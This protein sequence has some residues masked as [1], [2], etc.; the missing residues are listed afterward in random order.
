[1]KTIDISAQLLN[2]TAIAP[3]VMVAILTLVLLI[4]GIFA[5][6]LSAKFYISFCLISISLSFALLLG[7]KI[8]QSGFFGMIYVDKIS[9]LAQIIVLMAS[10]LFVALHFEKQEFFECKFK[11]YFVLFLFSLIGF[12]LMLSSKNLILIF[13][14]LE[15]SSLCIYTMIALNNR[16]NS[17]AAAIKYFTMGSFSSAFF[18]LGIALIY[19]F[20]GSFEIDEILSLVNLADISPLFLGGVMILFCALGFKLS[21]IPFHS[22]IGDVYEA[23][24]PALAGYIATIPKMA[25]LI[26]LMRF[27]EPLCEMNIK[28][29]QN[30]LYFIAVLT[31]SF[32]NLMAYA[33]KDV[34]KM[35]AFS[36]ISHSGFALSAILL[37][38]LM[39]NLAL[40]LYWIM[41]LV[42]NLGAFAMLSFLRNDSQSYYLEDF[43]ALGT[44]SPKFAAIFGLFMLSLAGIP[45]F[46]LFFGKMVLFSATIS[47]N[48]IILAVIMALNSAL[49]VYYYLRPIVCM[50]FK[51]TNS[52]KIPSNLTIQSTLVLVFALFASGFGLFYINWLYN[53]ILKTIS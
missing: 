23:I 50:Y 46:S 17:I 8:P 10:F 49:S 35:L 47:Q 9:F 42:A 15:L 41:F 2:F 3:I 7:T 27:F 43:K 34:K 1:M 52:P 13:I 22:W 4:I 40:F 39:G 11:E 36:S 6:N 29:V 21:L 12:L 14:S 53:F 32:G 28:L 37:G 30:S 26:V 5:R 44:N 16:L 33:Q 45:P 38:S 31:M 19:A 25:V 24:S 48:F 20:S 51:E 18:A